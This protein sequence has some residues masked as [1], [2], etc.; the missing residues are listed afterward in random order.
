[1]AASGTVAATPVL[2]SRF[3]RNASNE[4]VCEGAG[5]GGAQAVVG[6][7]TDMRVKY[8]GQAPGTTN[9]QYHPSTYAGPWSNIYAIEVCLELTGTEA[10]PTS[11]QTYKNCSDNDTPYGDRLKMVFRNVFQI[12]SQGLS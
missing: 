11:G 4:L 8:I 2:T 9:L 1:M 5:G 7:V 12:R 10:T 3:E 6:N